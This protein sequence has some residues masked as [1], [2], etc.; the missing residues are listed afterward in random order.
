MTI[1]E[2][3]T[4]ISNIDGA[5]NGRVN[6]T[7]FVIVPCEDGVVKISTSVALEKETKNHKPFNLE[8]AVADYRAW[9]AEAALKLAEKANKEPRV[10]GPNPE[11]QARRDELD[12]Q[13][14]SMPSFTE[15]TATDLMNAV[16]GN[17]SF[18]LTPMNVGQAAKRLVANG[19]LTSSV[20]E[21]RKTYY[22]KA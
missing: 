20:K 15:Y 14:T 12:A 7:N 2:L 18:K 4:L 5:V 6:K 21:D 9:E 3:K 11:A 19:V 17:V 13:I 8:A 1:N 10:K 22:T 16:A